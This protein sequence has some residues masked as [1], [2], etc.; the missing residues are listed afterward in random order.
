MKYSDGTA[1]IELAEYRDTKRHGTAWAADW[2]AQRW[3]KT[4]AV[5]IDAQ[6][7]AMVLLP[8]LKSRGVKVMVNT[9]NGMGQACGRVLDMLTAGTLKHLPDEAQP[10]LATAVANATTRPIGKSGAFGWNKAGSDI[11]ISPLVACT[12]ALQG[13]WTTRRNPNRRQHVMH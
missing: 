9:T 12:M 1:H 7:P 3:P 2:I 6:S 4:A 5:V 13:A 8:E 11:D 10:Q